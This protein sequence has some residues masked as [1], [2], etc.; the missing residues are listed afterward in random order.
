MARRSGGGECSPRW[1]RIRR[2]E[3]SDAAERLAQLRLAYPLNQILDEPS[4]RRLK[5]R[6]S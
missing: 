2:P 1:K 4:Y 6:M 5:R 3:V